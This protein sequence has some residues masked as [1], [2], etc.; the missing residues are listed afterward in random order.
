MYDAILTWQRTTD[1]PSDP[2]ASLLLTTET[3]SYCYERSDAHEALWPLPVWGSDGVLQLK[4]VMQLRKLTSPAH[5]PSRNT[6]AG[7][8]QFNTS[9]P[10]LW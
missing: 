7:P 8:H 3:E 1:Q 10:L 2:R 5:P 9:L 6:V 4:A